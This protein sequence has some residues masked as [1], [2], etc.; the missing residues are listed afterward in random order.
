ME[1][2]TERE[3]TRVGQG[4]DSGALCRSDFGDPCVKI[5][6]GDGDAYDVGGGS[7]RLNDDEDD[8]EEAGGYGNMG[9]REVEFGRGTDDGLENTVDDVVAKGDE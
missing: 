9:G 4:I 3:R 1:S 2:D 5:D 7:D 8:D 6:A